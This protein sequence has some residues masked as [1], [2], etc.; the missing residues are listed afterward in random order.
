MN[1]LNDNWEVSGND[2]GHLQKELYGMDERTEILSVRSD[3]MPLVTLMGT[4]GDN[5]WGYVHQSPVVQKEINLDEI[6]SPDIVKE[7][8]QI[9][10]LLMVG[11]KYYPI[12]DRF[13]PTLFQRAGG[14]SGGELSKDNNRELQFYWNSAIGKY[15]QRHPVPIRLV[16]KTDESGK[17][18]LFAA[19]SSRFALVSQNGFMKSILD[20]FVP[21]MGQP[22]QVRY[23]VSNYLTSVY[24]EFPE[25]ARDFAAVYKLPASMIPGALILTSDV[26][27]CSCTIYGTYRMG[28]TFQYVPG[29]SY[30]RIHTLNAGLKDIRDGI[31]REVFPEY[32]KLPERLCELLTIDVPDPERTIESVVKQLGI[33]RVY[34][35][36]GTRDIIDRIKSNISPNNNYT[37]YDICQWFFEEGDRRCFEKQRSCKST[38]EKSRNL[39]LKAAFCKY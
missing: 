30:K 31:N 14:V 28:S 16:K 12:G 19:M 5:N 20:V 2:L 27:E 38:Q 6:G 4:S 37:A 8:R 13:M 10:T 25:K 39:F 24:L 1:I 36:K 23:K 21:E 11:D 3:R 18:K 26:G 9:G 7:T 29:A 15:L 22:D 17:A 35:L 33:E 32:T 34:L